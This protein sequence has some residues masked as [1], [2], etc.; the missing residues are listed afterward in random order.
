MVNM[1]KQYKYV[2][3]LQIMLTYLALTK[4]PSVHLSVC[5]V[6]DF[7]G[8]GFVLLNRARDD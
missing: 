7:G 2:V 1:L 5:N 8:V 4:G 3:F 6:G